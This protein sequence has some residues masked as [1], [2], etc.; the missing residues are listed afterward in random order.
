MPAPLTL[1]MVLI[2]RNMAS[3]AFRQFASDVALSRKQVAIAADAMGLEF[4]DLTGAMTGSLLA[5][6]GLSAGLL[7]SG[8]VAGDFRAGI[9]AA[10][11][12][13]E[14]TSSQM[15]ALAN[16]A[17]SAEVVMRGVGPTQAARALREIGA[18]G[19]NASEAIELLVPALDLARAS[20]GELSP[21][22]SGGLIVQTMRI[23][24]VEAEKASHVA[25]LLTRASTV[26]A[27]RLE[28]MGLFLGIAGTS[29]AAF[30]VSMEDSL[31]AAALIRGVIPRVERGATAIRGLF[32]DLADV[33]RRQ[34][35]ATEFGVKAIDDS[36]G[37]FRNIF[38]IVFDLKT[39]MSGLTDS[40][41]EQKLQSVFQ[42]EAMQGIRGVL[43]AL[44]KGFRTSTGEIMKGRDA[45]AFLRGEFANAEG[46]AK[47][48][49]KIQSQQFG[50]S[51][52]NLA[53]SFELLRV[54]VG[55]LLRIL[56]PVFNVMAVGLSKLA[57]WLLNAPA[58]IKAPL[59]LFAVFA[60]VAGLLAAKFLLIG[61]AFGSIQKSGLLAIPA[62]KAFF[63]WFNIGLT[64]T[65]KRL[66]LI[67]LGLLAVSFVLDKLGV[68]DALL[69]SEYGGTK[70]SEQAKADE[71]LAK[72]TTAMANA[73]AGSDQLAALVSGA[74]GGKG[75]DSE[76]L[77]ASLSAL[78]AALS[79]KGQS[80]RGGDTFLLDGQ[81]LIERMKARHQ[82]EDE[83]LFRKRAN[84]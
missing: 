70:F 71:G 73:G 34:K 72:Q 76:E 32:D 58:W 3:P 79:R 62:I 67:V 46:A 57:G 25:D 81:V 31:S 49:A 36:T 63:A 50:G 20:F 52:A 35:L 43:S 22:Q 21:E 9:A 4:S 82:I 53:A 61:L 8:K 77:G 54:S 78:T 30:G 55:D 19:L 45:L 15:V 10:G 51:L 2:L 12:A 26:S 68:F 48:L 28:K 37:S 39:A 33:Q 7:T 40:Q 27:I 74:V 18:E 66:G 11:F 42:I 14:A 59:A 38:D 13:S 16:A 64:A 60:V 5:L 17:T 56:A 24:N 75:D 23:F 41:R 84:P 1:P 80:E 65:M 44:D 47:R 69:G 83:R 6:A 29:A